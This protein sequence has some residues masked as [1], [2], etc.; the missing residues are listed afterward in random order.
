MSLQLLFGV[1]AILDDGEMW[2]ARGRRKKGECMETRKIL[3]LD[4]ESDG[5][6]GEAFAIGAVV[7]IISGEGVEIIDTFSGV[8]EVE[9]IEN[10]WVRENVLPALKDSGLKKFS[11]RKEMR[12]A[13]WDFYK[14]WKDQGAEI[15]GDVIWPVEANFFSQLIADGEGARDWDG[16]YPFHDLGTILPPDVSR[17]EFTGVVYDHNP[18]N[19][20]LASVHA[21][22]IVLF[23]K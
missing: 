22:Q 2:K 19:D 7:A 12:D 6:H 1:Q 11:S 16:P 4:I 9:R 17:A 23:K 14:K 18:V 8:A 21:L 3:M 13:F 20:A 10:E 5:L 15:W